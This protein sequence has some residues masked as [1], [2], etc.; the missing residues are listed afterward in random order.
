MIITQRAFSA[1][2]R[3]ITKGDEML[4]ELVRIVR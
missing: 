4:D 2:T 3:V 1:N